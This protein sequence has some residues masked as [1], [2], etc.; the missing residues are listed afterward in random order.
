MQRR[1]RL[2]GRPLAA[3]VLAEGQGA[4]VQQEQYCVGPGGVDWRCRVERGLH[5]LAKRPGHDVELE[6][7]AQRRGL[8]HRDDEVDGRVAQDAELERRQRL[9]WPLAWLSG[10][11]A[12]EGP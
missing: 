1:I 4:V 10:Q 5:H 7:V 11:Q 12:F 6:A 9:G 3:V 2:E 8:Q